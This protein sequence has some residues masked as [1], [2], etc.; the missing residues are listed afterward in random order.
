MSPADLM[1][2]LRPVEAFSWNEDQVLDQIHLLREGVS[3]SRRIAWRSEGEIDDE[4]VS[5]V[6]HL[7]PPTDGGGSG[8]DRWR[9]LYFY[10]ALYY[11]RGLS[12]INVR[13]QR[14]GFAAA[15]YRIDDAS[16]LE[17]IAALDTP[18]IHHCSTCAPL[19]DE[20]LAIRIGGRSLFLVPRLRY[21]PVPFLGI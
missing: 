19:F 20:G 5:L 16:I 15:M 18:T 12:F 11:R 9:T 3:H 17:C 6:Q 10:G 8:G 7:I 4:L 13:E 14:T 1:V 21:P 2:D